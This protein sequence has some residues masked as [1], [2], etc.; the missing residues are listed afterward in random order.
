[1]PDRKTLADGLVALAALA[2]YKD[3]R[4]VLLCTAVVLRDAKTMS[5]ARKWISAWDGPPT[6]T[7]GVHRLLNLI[8]GC[9]EQERTAA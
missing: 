3:H 8:E 5:Q 9:D 2:A 4:A 7:A 6:V 1:V